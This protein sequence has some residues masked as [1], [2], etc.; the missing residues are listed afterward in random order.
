MLL[1]CES[2]T[3]GLIRTRLGRLCRALEATKPGHLRTESS[4]QRKDLS[5]AAEVAGFNGL[6]DALASL[7]PNH[8]AVNRASDFDSSLSSRSFAPCSGL[9][10]E[11]C[12]SVRPPVVLLPNPHPLPPTVYHVVAARTM[13]RGMIS[14][15][16]LNAGILL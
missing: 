16:P 5:R 9:L 11:S 15:H 3:Y 4:W 1:T 8:A 6:G 13:R 12:I 10:H 2:E 7:P 14:M